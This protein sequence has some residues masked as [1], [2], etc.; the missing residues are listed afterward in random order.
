MILKL[1]SLEKTISEPSEKNFSDFLITLLPIL[2]PAFSNVFIATL[3]ELI[4]L[5]HEGVSSGNA[6]KGTR[7]FFE[8]VIIL[9]STIGIISPSLFLSG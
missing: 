2:I 3:L 9:L 1:N 4:N 8:E 7:I 6:D 5:I